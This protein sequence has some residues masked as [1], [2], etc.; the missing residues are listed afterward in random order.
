[1][2]TAELL[3]D[4]FRQICLN[5]KAINDFVHETN[6]VKDEDNTL[7]K[8]PLAAWKL[9]NG[10]MERLGL[11]EVLTDT[12]TVFMAFLDQTATDRSALEMLRA[13]SRMDIIARQVLR[14]FSEQYLRGDGEFRPE[15]WPVNTTGIATDFELL[16]NPVLTRIYDTTGQH[17]TGVELELAIRVKGPVECV[18]NYFA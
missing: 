3:Y 9:P 8:Y 7:N 17:R 16:G 2:T 10:G 1:V 11:S 18:D 12:Y 15:D 13:H 5:H 6:L 14:Q 4:I